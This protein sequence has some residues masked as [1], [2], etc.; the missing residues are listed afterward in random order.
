[1]KRNI[2]ILAFTL[3]ALFASVNTYAKNDK[4]YWKDKVA[5]MTEAQK[6]ARITEMKAR[7][8]AIK[9]MDKS[10]LSREDRKA[11][12]LELRDMNKEA[13]AMGSGGIYIS[14]AGLLIIILVLI[15]VL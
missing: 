13:K 6:E 2:A 12:R 10:E 7:V 15:L 8:E 11:L 14:L 3:L 5:T 9:D 1:M 4:D